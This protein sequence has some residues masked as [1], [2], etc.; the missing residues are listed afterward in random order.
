MTNEADVLKALYEAS[1]ESTVQT[2]RTL[3]RL[4][5]NGSTPAN[6]PHVAAATP[7]ASD[8]LLELTRASLQHYN[9]ML[10]L[11]ARYTDALVDC[12]RDLARPAGAARRG[13]QRLALRAAVGA[14][15]TAEFDVDNPA[16]EAVDLTFAVSELRDGTRTPF[17]V[18]ARIGPVDAGDERRVPPRTTRRFRLTLPV[19]APL[20][21]GRHYAGDLLIV[22]RG[23]AVDQIAL[24]LD[25]EPEATRSVPRATVGGAS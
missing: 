12:L 5:G 21:A 19:V 16:G 9:Q 15:A 7:R 10:G 24:G 14:D 22:H 25:V 23:R 13:G 8:V 11:S 1:L 17:T 18:A 3:Y 20:E 4:K 6:E 2:L